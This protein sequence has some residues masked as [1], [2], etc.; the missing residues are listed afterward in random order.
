MFNININYFSLFSTDPVILNPNTSLPDFSVSD[1]LTSV[2]SCPFQQDKPNP[3]P[4]H[5]NCVVLGYTDGTH[6]W[7]IE[8]GNSQYWSL[9]V[10]SG[11]VEISDVYI[12]TP[13]KG[14]WGIRC[15]GSSF[16]L[17]GAQISRLKTKGNPEVIPV[18]LDYRCDEKGRYW[19][20]RF[21]DA[22][23]NYLI[24]EFNAVPGLKLSPFVIPEDLGTLRVVPANIILTVEQKLQFLE[25]HLVII[26]ICLCFVMALTFLILA[27]LIERHNR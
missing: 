23:N 1:D 26:M 22:G 18:K 15:F 5:K 14:F 16:E 9:G 27:W 8:V 20:V 24:A 7:E 17:M 12:L 13:A 25:R 11:S 21:F 10:C 2:T 19:Y 3:F 6:T 4:Q